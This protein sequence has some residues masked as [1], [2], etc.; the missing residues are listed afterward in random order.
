MGVVVRGG[1]HEAASGTAKDTANAAT[2]DTASGTRGIGKGAPV[3]GIPGFVAGGTTDAMTSSP[4]GS[5][6][7][8]S[9][10]RSTTR[11]TTATGTGSSTRF[12]T[13]SITESTTAGTTYIVG[14]GPR[15]AAGSLGLAAPTAG[16]GADAEAGRWLWPVPSHTPVAG[17]AA[18][19][20]RYAAG[21]RGID[22][23]VTPG[24]PVA[25][26]AEAVVRFAGVVVDRPVVTLDHG[27]GVLS[28]YEPVVS[29]LPVGSA[30]ARGAVIGTVAAGGHCADMCLHLGVRVDGEYVSPLR[31]LARVPRAILLPLGPSG[32]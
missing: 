25:A 2:Y 1:T 13:I 26:P 4:S 12:T 18:P 28:S 20:T 27:G 10:T 8:T 7:A 19:P 30:V 3:R 17:Y 15:R 16:V 22:L 9:S 6:S 29:A 31:F 5:G 11:R 24:T 21:H 32:R 23:S 14:V